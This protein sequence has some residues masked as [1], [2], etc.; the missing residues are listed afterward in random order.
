MTSSRNGTSDLSGCS[1]VS[2]PTTLPTSACVNVQRIWLSLPHRHR[3]QAVLMQCFASA[4]LWNTPSKS[5][6]CVKGCPVRQTGFIE[7]FLHRTSVI[8]SHILFTWLAQCGRPCFNSPA[9]A[10]SFPAVVLKMW[11]RDC[12]CYAR[13]FLRSYYKLEAVE[14]NL[15]V[16]CLHPVVCTSSGS[17]FPSNATLFWIFYSVTATCFGLMTILRWNSLEDG[18]KTETCSGYWIKYSKQCYVRRK[19]WTWSCI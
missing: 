7:R 15:K 10:R 19:P 11:S 9:T 14:L 18:H 8:T 4:V 13:L 16:G 6:H 3:V 12:Y 17:G 1:V 2:Q 5:D